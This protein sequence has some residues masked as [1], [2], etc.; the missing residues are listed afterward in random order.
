MTRDEADKLMDSLGKFFMN[1]TKDELLKLAVENRFQLGPC[2]NAED[3]LKHPQL[4][5]RKFWQEIDHPVAGKLKYPGAP[6]KLSTT[7]GIINRP[8]PLLGE[9]NDIVYGE[10][11]KYSQEQLTKMKQAGI[12]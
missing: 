11:L 6:F 4:E 3:V 12:I 7:P 2:N 9:H 10:I 1:H 5:A 8:A